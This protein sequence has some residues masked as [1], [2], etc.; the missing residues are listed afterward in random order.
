MHTMPGKFLK[1][2][3]PVVLVSRVNP[4]LVCGRGSGEGGAA[5]IPEVSARLRRAQDRLEILI[6]KVASLK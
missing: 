6:T 4:R 1:C 2:H 3:F 5:S